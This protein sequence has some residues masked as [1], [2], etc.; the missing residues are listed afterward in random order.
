MTDDRVVPFP[1]K[2]PRQLTLFD[3]EQVIF[4]AAY[5]IAAD[6]AQR[7]HQLDV[8][9]TAAVLATQERGDIADAI[10]TLM[11]VLMEDPAP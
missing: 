5:A 9:A 8:I 1:R 2:E 3:L 4:D 10:Q 6:P 7:E 11:Q